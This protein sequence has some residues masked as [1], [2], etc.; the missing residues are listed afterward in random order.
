LGLCLIK[1]TPS[2][3]KYQRQKE[4]KSI[5]F[6]N[7]K[8]VDQLVSRLAFPTNAITDIG[9]FFYVLALLF[10]DFSPIFLDTTAHLSLPNGGNSM[11]GNERDAI[12]AARPFWAFRLYGMCIWI[13]DKSGYV[14]RR[15]HNTDPITIC[16]LILYRV[17]RFF[18]KEDVEY[19]RACPGNRA[20][21]PCSNTMYGGSVPHIQWREA[22]EESQMCQYE[23]NIA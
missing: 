5:L 17:F 20:G 23:S 9:G 22:V 21:R 11:P 8:E 10:A 4:V 1:S 6:H 2:G 12:G 18:S 15:N 3:V 14:L 16:A 19:R 13:W 7:V